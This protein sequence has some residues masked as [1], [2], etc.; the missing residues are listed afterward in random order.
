MRKTFASKRKDVTEDCR[1]LHNEEQIKK[2]VR[3]GESDTYGDN[4]SAYR[5][6]LGKP[7][8]KR[9]PGRFRCK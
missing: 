1:K 8:K 7:E 3:G 2:N 4:R 6:L 9:P 5:V